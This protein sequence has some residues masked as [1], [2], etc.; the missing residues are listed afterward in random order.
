MTP[1]LAFFC[2]KLFL[3]LLAIQNDYNI[4]YKCSF[5]AKLF[6]FC[7]LSHFPKWEKHLKQPNKIIGSYK[8]N[9]IRLFCD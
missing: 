6:I 8:K 9:Y 1:I 4:Q 3:N 7:M 2:C 5:G